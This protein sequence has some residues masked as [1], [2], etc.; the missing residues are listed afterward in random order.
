[1]F[2]FVFFCFFFLIEEDALGNP[3]G[4]FNNLGTGVV[5]FFYEPAQGLVK[6]PKDFSVGLAKVIIEKGIEG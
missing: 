5:D 2:L 4:L 1:M 3:V 6:S